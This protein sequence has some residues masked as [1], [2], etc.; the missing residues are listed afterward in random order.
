MDSSTATSD[1]SVR[2]V[3]EV[4]PGDDPRRLLQGGWVLT[5]QA[6]EVVGG[7]ACGRRWWLLVA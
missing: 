2:F 5:R 3:K 7:R 4:L 1:Q 6:L